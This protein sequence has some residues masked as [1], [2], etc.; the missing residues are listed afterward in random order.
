MSI[1]NS[2]SQRPPVDNVDNVDNVDVDSVDLDEESRAAWWLSALD[3]PRLGERVALVRRL[4]NC[5][6]VLRALPPTS[7]RAVKDYAEKSY[8]R[9]LD[10]GIRMLPLTSPEYPALLQEITD[11]PLALTLR[12]HL[13]REE[14]ALAVVGSRRATRYGLDVTRRLVSRLARLGF[15]IV[16]GLARG[17]DAA[18]HRAALSAGGRTIAVLGSGLENIYPREHEG[19]AEEILERGAVISEFEP[20]A[21]PLARH[22]PRRNRIVTGL[23]W[24]TLVIEAASKSG[25]LISARHALEQDREVFAVPAAV[26]GA[27]AEG[28][29]ELLRDGA[30]LT[31]R[32]EDI[33]DQLRPDL[34]E[35]LAVDQP[36]TGRDSP[37][38]VPPMDAHERAVFER[39]VDLGRAVDLDQILEGA[40]LRPDQALA[41]LLRLEMQGRIVALPGGLYQKVL[42]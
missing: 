1:E 4:G 14:L 30:R 15:T 12:G 40:P 17:I 35:R 16:S 41:A 3:S 7:V 20:D 33:T 27:N 19:L 18:A 24:G 39:L 13:A 26:G 25:S 28:V 10:A 29:F 32:V 9:A 31:A 34:R 22:F 36:E 11:P 38:R 2:T 21:A 5:Q 37:G 23:C 8:A 42:S 6:A